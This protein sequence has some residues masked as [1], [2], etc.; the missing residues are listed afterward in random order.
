MN[1][2]YYNQWITS[3]GEDPEIAIEALSKVSDEVRVDVLITRPH[4]F[5][6]VE[7]A[8]SGDTLFVY[9]IIRAFS[10]LSDTAEMMKILRDKGVSVVSIDDNL[11]ADF[12]EAGKLAYDTIIFASTLVGVEPNYRSYR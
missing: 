8:K 6:I 5:E 9:K 1:Y 3:I 10:G 12:T 4:L 7:K 11:V 2:G